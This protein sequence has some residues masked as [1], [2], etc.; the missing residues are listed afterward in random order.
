MLRVTFGAL[1]MLLDLDDVE[2]RVLEDL[3]ETNVEILDAWYPDAEFDYDPVVFLAQEAFVCAIAACESLLAQEPETREQQLIRMFAVLENLLDALAG[4]DL[5][6]TTAFDAEERAIAA[7]PIWKCE[8]A[9]R[10]QLLEALGPDHTSTIDLESSSAPT[11]EGL[12]LL[13]RRVTAWCDPVAVA[14]FDALRPCDRR[15]IMSLEYDVSYHLHCRLTL[16]SGRSIVL[17]LLHQEKSSLIEGVPF[18]E[19]ND[20]I[21]RGAVALPARYGIQVP[22]AYLVPPARRDYLRVPGDMNGV[23]AMGNRDPEWLP[24]VSCVGVFRSSGPAR[25]PDKD[26]SCLTVV[27]FQDEFAM[28]IAE[29][30]LAHLKEIA[31]EDLAQDAEY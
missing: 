14:Q 23:R 31:W 1:V 2:Q 8:S 3:G 25:D 20:H 26:F 9:R 16:S 4:A 6:V 30:V 21:V 15:E 19:L 7:H 13:T 17:T 27:W 24:I 28:P 5:G 18:K 12:T 29:P 10:T 22:N 11:R